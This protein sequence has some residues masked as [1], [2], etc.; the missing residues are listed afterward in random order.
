MSQRT[1]TARRVTPT[2]PTSHDERDRVNGPPSGRVGFDARGNA[3]WEWRTQDQKFVRDASTTLVRRLHVPS[4]ALEQTGIVKRVQQPVPGWKPAVPI[5]GG[6]P[7]QRNGRVAMGAA[8]ERHVPP[9]KGSKIVVTSRRKPGL[10]DRLMDW[11]R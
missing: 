7:Y 1:A 9:R 3:V 10:F 2:F 11:M 8:A 5:E 6:S 4:L